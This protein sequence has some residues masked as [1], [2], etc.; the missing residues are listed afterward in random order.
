MIEA[1]I[2]LLALISGLLVGL[3]AFAVTLAV[4][5]NELAKRQESLLREEIA[6]SIARAVT[7]EAK[8]SAV[9]SAIEGNALPWF[10]K[11]DK[12]DARYER[13]ALDRME[14]PSFY[15]DA[16]EGLGGVR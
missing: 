11:S 16:V 10:P 2:A 8:A 15:A 7:A 3:S 5:L 1:I 6:I 14:N 12:M 13:E 4:M 9:T